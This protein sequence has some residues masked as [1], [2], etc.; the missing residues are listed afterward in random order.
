MAITAKRLEYAVALPRLDRIA[1][2][3][4]DPVE[5]GPGW[6]AEHLVLAGLTR[7]TL[8][9]LRYH[10]KRCAV[11]VT[12]MSGSASGVV[13]KREEDGRYAFVEIDCALDVELE[14]VPP[15]EE[16]AALLAKAERDCFISASL[17]VEP[18]YRWRVNGEELA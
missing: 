6:E 12:T 13:T 8:T 7:C 14:P 10:A 11:G 2:E 1:P 3:G 17:T 15:E 4:S 16:L 18:R 9:S 5:L